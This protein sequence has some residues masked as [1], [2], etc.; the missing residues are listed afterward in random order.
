MQPMGDFFITTLTLLLAV[1][2]TVNACPPSDRAAL[3]AFKSALN[4]SSSI[5]IFNTW[6]GADCCAGWYGVT[7]DPET[8]RVADI[9][10]RADSEDPIFQKAGRSGYMTGS[11]HPSI[12]QL[13][14]L[15]TLVVADWKAISGRIPL[16]LASLPR[17]R[18]LDLIGNKLSGEIP[19]D[20]GNL[21]RLTV[22]DLAY[23]RISGSIPPS[24]V[25]LGSLMHLDLSNNKL[26]GIIPSDVGK[27]S[28]MS[29]ALLS[30]NRLT[31]SIPSSTAY[32]H[33]LADLD[34]SENRL[35]GPIP[36][37]LGSMPV[38]STLNLASNELAGEMPNTLLSNTN[39]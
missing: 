31:G 12:C 30:R 6:A 19:A 10:L 39:T 5:G 17:L 23:N 27:L 18:I 4:E 15:V 3:L 25:N 2:L 11:I 20:I 28:M 29:R 32:I 16:C 36:D 14:R 24:I 38:L 8:N 34:L 21:S 7:C 26:V 22:L 1:A 13:D 33:R 35:T 9:V 37:H